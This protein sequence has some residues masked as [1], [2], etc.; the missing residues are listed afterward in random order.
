MIAATFL[1]VIERDL[2]K[3]KEEIRM[4]PDE[5]LW[6]VQGDIKNPAGTLALHLTGNLKH[7]IGAI[8]G[9]TGYMRERD[10]EFSEKNV[11]KEKLL[12]GLEEA[13]AVVKKVLNGLPDEKVMQQYPIE[14]FGKASSTL[15]VLIQLAAHLN[16]HLGQVNYLRRMV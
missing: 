11:P 13:S 2:G 8:L 6:V 4:F 3:L 16:Y 5:R 1:E 12:E 7:F 14:A 9:N 15:Y 10:K